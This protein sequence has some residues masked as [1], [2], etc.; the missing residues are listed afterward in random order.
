MYVV[1]IQSWLILVVKLDCFASSIPGTSG[2]SRYKPDTLLAM[3]M[4]MA[5]FGYGYGYGLCLAMAMFGYG[6][7]WLWL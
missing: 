5:M 4:A 1:Y 2:W 7:V 6:Y 3:A